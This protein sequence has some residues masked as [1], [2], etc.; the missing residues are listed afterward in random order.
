MAYIVSAGSTINKPKLCATHWLLNY[1]I[2]QWVFINKSTLAIPNN[3]IEEA[4]LMRQT[5]YNLSETAYPIPFFSV[6]QPLWENKVQNMAVFT[7]FWV[8]ICAQQMTAQWELV[9]ECIIPVQRASSDQYVWL[10]TD[11][12]R[13]KET[14]T[15]LGN[16]INCTIN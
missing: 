5:R 15:R 2:S 6:P 10:A 14:L 9:S 12:G 7:A 8:E 3:Q 4:F 11:E 13:G 1:Q 16:K